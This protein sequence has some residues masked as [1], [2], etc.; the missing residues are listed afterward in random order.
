MNGKEADAVQ[1]RRSHWLTALVIV[2]VIAYAIFALMNMRTKVAEANETEQ[3]LRQK[4]EQIQEENAALQ[5]AI[6][7]QY[8]DKTIEDIARDRLGLVLPDEK[9]FY[10]AGE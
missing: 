8:D 4:M 3:Q 2:G 10:D 1:F 6:D 5:Y 9:I 7:H